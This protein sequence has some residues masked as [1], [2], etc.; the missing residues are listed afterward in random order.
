MFEVRGESVYCR[1]YDVSLPFELVDRILSRKVGRTKVA[2]ELGGVVTSNQAAYIL[3]WLRDPNIFEPLY[4]KKERSESSR[5]AD[6]PPAAPEPRIDGVRAEDHRPDPEKLFK[7]AAEDYASKRA[8]RARARDNRIAFSGEHPV[9]IAWIADTHIGNSGTDIE[10]AFREI[11][12]VRDTPGM[13]A[14]FVGDLIDNFVIG[15]LKSVN[16]GQ[17]ATIEDQWILGQYY[18]RQAPESWLGYVSGNHEQWSLRVAGY[19]TNREIVPRHC[20]YDTDE[21]D[22]TV[23]LNGHET[24]VIARHR[25]PGNSIYNPLHPQTRGSKFSRPGRDIYVGAHTHPGALAADH[26]AGD[27]RVIGLVQCGTYKDNDSFARTIGFPET[28]HTTAA[29]T[30]FYPDGRHESFKSLDTVRDILENTYGSPR[31]ELDVSRD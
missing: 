26:P 24:K 22:F 4:S 20:L 5:T 8:K 18:L 17:R 19:D 2:R 29:A 6:R 3:S 27:G 15:V 7:R 14:F 13:F 11:G 16:L 10:R 30:I 21:I 23:E 25:W 9:A 1:A 12:I 31:P 28:G